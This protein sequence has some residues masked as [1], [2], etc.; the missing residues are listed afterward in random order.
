[1]MTG[2]YLIVAFL[3]IGLIKI[4]WT[5]DD[6]KI[7]LKYNNTLAEERNNLMKEERK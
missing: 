4:S 2:I 7:E 1:M 6:I 3:F 5:L